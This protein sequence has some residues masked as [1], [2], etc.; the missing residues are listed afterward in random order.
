LIGLL[1]EMEGR[2]QAFPASELQ[3]GIAEARVQLTTCEAP[4]NW[5]L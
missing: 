5:R 4:G 1:E 2:P 3:F